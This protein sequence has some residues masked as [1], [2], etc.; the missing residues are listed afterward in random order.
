MPVTMEQIKK[1]RDKT[2]AGV[3]DCKKALSEADGDIEK[4]IEILRKKGTAVAVKKSQRITNA[5]LI[6]AYIHLGGKIGVIVEVN[7]ETDF[8]ARN[9]MF[10]IFVKDIAMQI[11]ASVP[12]YIKREEVPQELIDKEKEIIKSQ[13]GDKKPKEILEKITN[14]KLDKFF[15]EVCLLEQPF[16]KDDKLTVGDY[17]TSIIAKIGENI[18]IR[19]FERFQ[20]GEEL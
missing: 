7:C 1:L 4:A 16:I 10:K 5:G 20:L 2:N 12:K 13:I 6:D 11:T 9:D 17:L 15:A 18:I 19:R 8:V 3:V 14:G